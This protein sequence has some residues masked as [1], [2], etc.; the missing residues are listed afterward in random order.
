MSRRNNLDRMGVPAPSSDAPLQD[1]GSTGGDT[2]NFV[3]PTEFVE[4]PSRGLYYPEGHPLHK[5]EE[6][7]IRFMT[8]KEEDILTSRS[9]LQKGVAIDKVL[10][11]IVVDKKVNINDLFIGDKNAVII[12]ARASAYG[13]DYKT[14]ITC[15][16]CGTKD[17]FQFDLENKTISHGNTTGE[18]EIKNTSN[19]TF[20]V[21]LPKTGAHVEIRLLNG[22]DEKKL[23]GRGKDIS[24]NDFKLTEQFKRF[25]VTVEGVD[26]RSLI[27]RFI[28]NMPAYDSRYLRGAYAEVMPN[29][30][31]TQSYEC[32]FCGYQ[33]DMEVPF[34]SEF[35]WPK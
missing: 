13:P 9:L 1:N 19:G 17:D 23:V 3:V 6:I 16:Q 18:H 7:E 31:L 26:D 2:L 32:S 29:V 33:Q 25:I 27:E 4:L 28:N 12:A 5:K 34:T 20:M 14:N 24:K 30:D 35:F 22:H 21:K 15:P 10:Q 11:N 8:A